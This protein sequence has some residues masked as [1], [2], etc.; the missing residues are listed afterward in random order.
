MARPELLPDEI[1][2]IEAMG[3]APEARSSE[4]GPQTSGQ[5]ASPDAPMYLPPTPP[6]P[7]NA[8][9]AFSATDNQNELLG[10][11]VATR[12]VDSD[13][14]RLGQL[15]SQRQPAQK[16]SGPGRHEQEFTQRFAGQ[17]EKARKAFMLNWF[18][19]GPEQ[20][21]R[22]QEAYDRKR[23]EASRGLEAARAKDLEETRGQ[24][25]IT[26]AQ[27]QML[28]TAYGMTP[29]AVA[30]LTNEEW[31]RLEPLLK[32]TPYVNNQRWAGE[33]K[34]DLKLVEE[35][36]DLY[37]DANKN[38][39]SVTNTQLRGQNALNTV[40]ANKKK[41]GGGGMAG[42]RNV[43]SVLAELAD[44]SPEA[45]AIAAQKAATGGTAD[46]AAEARLMNQA[47]VLTDMSAKEFMDVRKSS[48]KGG[49]MQRANREA[50]A[51]VGVDAKRNDPAQRTKL[52]D[53]LL[54][55]GRA[56]SNAKSAFQ[57]LKNNGKIGLLVKVPWGEWDRV[58]N[59]EFTPEEQNAARRIAAFLNPEM[60]IQTGAALSG[61]E[62]DMSYTQFGITSK[63]DAFAS[64]ERLEGFLKD[65][66][67]AILGT[68]QAIE[69][70][71]PGI[72]EGL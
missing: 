43:A 21:Y 52:K 33:Q 4:I 44:V 40:N 68:R 39:T 6:E 57:L 9:A 34:K 26:D 42:P 30:N 71:Y 1:A 51:Q 66:G 7:G 60:R 16:Q 63:V 53:A 58:T 36:A 50:S 11:T 2:A 18:A 70:E 49:V 72:F 48:A 61:F 59:A 45:A 41:P 47:Q 19:G 22:F 38:A 69:S 55:R 5:M 25:P 17:D 67:R 15:R 13:I 65:S 14:G 64:P 12:D 32:S 29:E 46:D 10:K 8:K 23:G 37:K 3:L 24:A 56:Y 35:T 62:K 54:Q 31:A 27:A 20:A 28:V